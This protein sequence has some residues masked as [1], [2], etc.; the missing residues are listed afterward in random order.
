MSNILWCMGTTTTTTIQQQQQE[1]L[2]ERDMEREY[3]Y[4]SNKGRAGRAGAGAG[5]NYTTTSRVININA[6]TLND[7]TYIFTI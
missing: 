7:P 4:L 5:G 6:M 2:L 1:V 3:N